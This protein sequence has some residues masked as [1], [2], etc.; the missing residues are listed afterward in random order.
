MQFLFYSG[1]CVLGTISVYILFYTFFKERDRG[2]SKAYIWAI[3][4][5]AQIISMIAP[6]W[7][8]TNSELVNGAGV[9]VL[10]FA[11]TFGLTFLY[12]GS[13]KDRF[14]VTVS[15]QIIGVLSEMLV[16]V[17]FPI[18]QNET[19]VAA[20]LSQ[21]YIWSLLTN[22]LELSVIIIISYIFRTVWNRDVMKYT[23]AV[24]LT[25]ILSMLIIVVAVDYLS[26]D[27]KNIYLYQIVLILGISII[28]AIHYFLFYA[29]VQ[30]NHLKM[31][32]DQLREQIEFQTNKYQQISTAYKNTRS[33]LHDTKKHFF[34]LENCID[35]KNYDAMKEYLPT[36]T[37]RLER[38][39][40][41][42]NTGNLVIDAFVSNYLSIAQAEHIAFITDI[43]VELEKIPIQDYDFCIIL[44]NL[45]DNAIHAVRKIIPPRERKIK[46]QLFTKR[47]NFVVCIKNSCYEDVNSQKKHHDLI[48]GYGCK[49]VDHITTKYNGTYSAILEHDEYIAVV[50][51]PYDLEK[52]SYRG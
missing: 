42:I 20:E 3:L 32:N 23:I 41:R 19:L 22:S 52:D 12:E 28:N 45:L 29:V 37:K 27:S 18:S 31:E 33:I 24:F 2:I 4:L 1:S 39:Y 17:A 6:I 13:L 30:S 35:Q 43:K 25:P 46:V 15:Q 36:A 47:G 38:A 48:H 21:N 49:N 16:Y 26:V 10:N 5:V 9:M 7:F 44:G 11:I 8:H 40:N 51:M 34:Y 14:F 50:S